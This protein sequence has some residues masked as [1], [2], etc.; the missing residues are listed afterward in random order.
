[1]PEGRGWGG[2]G[3]IA[4]VLRVVLGPAASTS[5][6]NFVCMCAKSL[7][8]SPL[9]CNTMDHSPPGSSVHGLLQVRILEWVAM[10]S[11]RGSSQPRDRTQ[12]SWIVGRFFTIPSEPPENP[13][14]NM[15]NMQILSASL[16]Y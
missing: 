10:P 13:S 15:V 4:A 8:L 11:S 3:P 6:G 5:P 12:V 9:L 16:A 14:R 7:Q 1:M 2:A